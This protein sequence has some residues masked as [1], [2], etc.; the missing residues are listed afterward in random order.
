[1]ALSG[2]GGRS[3]PE[4]GPHQIDLRTRGTEA[5]TTPPQRE[6]DRGF[7]V[8]RVVT[9]MERSEMSVFRVLQ[10]SAAKP[11]ADLSLALVFTPP[12]PNVTARSGSIAVLLGVAGEIDPIDY[13]EDAL[14]R[15]VYTITNRFARISSRP[16]A[17]GP[18]S[19]HYI[20]GLA[21]KSPSSGRTFSS[22]PMVPP[23]RK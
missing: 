9:T 12:V 3:V 6:V 7:Y 22:G 14:E 4:P 10:T 20:G 18:E 8:D 15:L 17:T 23:C 13:A 21:K 1:M 11:T 16:T 5:S 19:A 2:R